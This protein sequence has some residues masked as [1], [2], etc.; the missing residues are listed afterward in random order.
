MLKSNIVQISKLI[1][2]GLFLNFFVGC[3]LFLPG[4]K[5]DLTLA[6]ILAIIGTGQASAPSN[7]TYTDSPFNFQINEDVQTIPPT[8]SGIVTSCISSPALPNGLVLD[9]SS[10]AIS[11]KP[12]ALQSAR[13]YQIKASNQGGSTLSNIII[14][15]VPSP[16]KDI[17]AFSILGN[18][19]NIF[20]GAIT[21]TVPA[22]TSVTSLVSTFTITGAS[23]NISGTPQLSGITTNN[24]TTPKVF[25]VVAADGTTKNYTITVTIPINRFWVAIASSADGSKL[26]AVSTNG[27]IYTSS[28]GG[29]SWVARESSRSW[30]GISS[31][32]DGTKLV[33]VVANGQIYTSSDSGVNWTARESIRNWSCVTSSSDGT[34]LIAGVNNGYLYTSI[35]SGLT[36]VARENT[37]N[38]FSLASTPDGS[39]IAAIQ[40]IA[41]VLYISS[42]SGETWMPR[43][44]GRSSRRSITIS[45]DGTKLAFAG[46]NMLYTSVDSGVTWVGRE[47]TRNYISVAGSS[48]GSK[49]AVVVTGGQIYISTDSGVNWTERENVKQWNFI[50]SSKDGTKLAAVVQD[51]QIYTSRDSGL[52]WSV[53]F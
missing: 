39:K 32:A 6:E 12:T 3:S 20:N 22:G 51:G 4:E 8:V 41:G 26:A 35:D 23:V 10:C 1:L 43:D 33:A 50:T 31:S 40:H 44:S 21:V 37:R 25:T 15:V 16:N 5:R 13:D 53:R 45:D 34:K 38:W 36:W 14:G 30:S 18:I 28:D 24:F 11:G 19:G 47:T 52:T 17:T 2:L 42:D 46:S 27:Q 49:L 9:Q 7:L 29:I 48:D